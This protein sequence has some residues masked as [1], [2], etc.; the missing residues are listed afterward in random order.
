MFGQKMK[1]IQ[2]LML[3]H[4]KHNIN[5]SIGEQKLI[6]FCFVCSITWTSPDMNDEQ[7]AAIINILK[8]TSYPYPYVLF[9]PPGTGKTKTLVEAI[10]QIIRND[11]P[12]EFILVCATSNSACDEVAKRLIDGGISNKVFRIFSRSVAM[13]TSGIPL[14]VLSSSNLAKG[15]HYFPSLDILCTYKV[16]VCTLTT[17]GRLSQGKIKPQHFSHIFIDEAGSATESQTL[18]A[19]AG[20]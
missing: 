3:V 6:Y 1:R 11:N 13:D 4:R 19:L 9:G 14:S 10:S 15:E 17:A 8:Q 2:A 20:K 5:C 7:K 18:I 16:V 12:M